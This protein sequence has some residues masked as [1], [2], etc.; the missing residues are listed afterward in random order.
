[1]NLILPAY[2]FLT[3][4]SMKPLERLLER[5]LKQGKEDANRLN[6]RKGYAGSPRPE[7]KLIWIHAASVGESQSALILINRLLTK[8]KN[9]HILITTGTVTSADV[10]N[11]NLPKGVVHQYYPLDHPAWVDSFLKH[12]QPDIALWMESELWPNMLKALKSQNIPAVLINARLSDKSFALWKIFKKDVQIIL[13]TF[14][15]V[16]CQTP[17]DEKRF[18][19]LGVPQ[20]NIHVTDNLKYSA[21]NLPYNEDDLKRLTGHILQRPVWVYASTH[22]GEEQLACHTHEIVKNAL[23]DL[24]TIIVPRHP[25]R[26]D[27]IAKTCA[28]Y[29]LNTVFRGE[30]KKKKLPAYDTDIYV[31]DTMGELG[32]FYRVAPL[33]CIGRS[34]SKDGGGGHNPIEA[35]QL[36]CAV[37]HGPHVQ[38]Q[39]QIYDDMDDAG[40]ALEMHR[41]QYL[42]ETVRTL[43]STNKIL[44]EQQKRAREFAA[45]KTAVIDRVWNHLS[46]ILL[47]TGLI[48]EA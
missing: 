16:L 6:E 3:Q 41:P 11:K 18:I 28:R 43:L 35:A 36:D 22:D 25:H 48:D 30:G 46:P 29:N 31:A 20:K 32:L 13:N 37:L 21:T 44:K 24:L 33:A 10:M 8:I 1:M 42:I 14:R 5:R 19:D 9:V 15:T 27:E 2:R 47:D 26:R 39:Q 38:F 12:W 45:S 40:A 17:L 4:R 34:F 7:G 23:P